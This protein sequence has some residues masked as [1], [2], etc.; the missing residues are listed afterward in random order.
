[1]SFS[2][3]AQAAKAKLGNW[4]RYSLS[5]R[6]TQPFRWLYL[7]SVLGR[8]EGGRGVGVHGAGVEKVSEGEGHVQ[9]FS[10]APLRLRGAPPELQITQAKALDELRDDN[11]VGFVGN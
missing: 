6:S 10:P 5:S 2:M 3:S 8:R 7:P 4:S 9:D 11:L 1:M